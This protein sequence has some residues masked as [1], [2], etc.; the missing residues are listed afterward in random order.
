MEEFAQFSKKLLTMN[1]TQKKLKEGM[2]S[3]FLHKMSSQVKK[4]NKRYLLTK[5]LVGGVFAKCKSG[6]AVAQYFKGSNEA[7]PEL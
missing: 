2:V 3:S 1:P 7:M 4:H 5:H 6:Q